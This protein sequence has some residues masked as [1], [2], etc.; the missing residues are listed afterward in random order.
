MGVKS[1]IDQDFSAGV[2]A[3]PSKKCFFTMT[4]ANVDET[5]AIDLYILA[6]FKFYVKFY[7]IE[8]VATS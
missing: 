4:I 8:N 7:E 5:T 6:K 2:G 1:L 3:D